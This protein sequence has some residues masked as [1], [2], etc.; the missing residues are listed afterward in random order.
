MSLVERELLRLRGLIDRM[1]G[2]TIR[3]FEETLRLFE[4]IDG[5]EREKVRR[6]I[7]DAS[8]ILEGF[9]HEV[10]NEVLV[11]IARR[12]PLGTDLILAERL[13]S[14]TY[15]LYRISRYLREIARIDAMLEPGGLSSISEFS[16][17][18][19]LAYDAVVKVVS[20]LRLLRCAHRDDVARIDEAIDHEY[21][22]LLNEVA[23]KSCIPGVEAL[24]VLLMRHIERIV[25]HAQYVINYL[26]ELGV[27]SG[28]GP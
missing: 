11:F 6:S 10:V 1:S 3:A 26:E 24:K 13:I 5:L 2:L 16:G 28:R 20:D 15:D 9:R 17:Y 23:S 18:L 7:N 21:R 12:Q 8:R 22:R 4:R 19:R 25:D 27:G 14:V